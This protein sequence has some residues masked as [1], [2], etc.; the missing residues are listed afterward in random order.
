MKTLTDERKDLIPM[1]KFRQKM[2]EK[3][4]FTLVE[5]IVVIAILGILAAVAVPTYTGYIAKAKQAS[6]L[7]ILS[8]VA[9]AVVGVEAGDGTTVD[10][11]VVK[12]VAS[13]AAT[14]TYS[15]TDKAGTAVND[16]AADAEC[17]TLIGLTATELNSEFEANWST[18]TMQ[19]GE[20]SL[21]GTTP[22]T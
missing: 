7:Q 20:W 14:V 16:K 10:K 22:T 18:A 3:A 17:Y 5:L 15:G 19:N 11:I 4:G 13:G 1:K 2:A 8:S 9:T 12:R 21:T 6:D